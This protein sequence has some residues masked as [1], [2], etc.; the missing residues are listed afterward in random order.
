MLLQPLLATITRQ[1]LLT[2]PTICSCRLIQ[3]KRHLI[4]NLLRALFSYTGTDITVIR[5]LHFDRSGRLLST[6][7]SRKP[8]SPYA[9]LSHRWG[10]AKIVFQDLGANA[11]YTMLIML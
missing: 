10:D 11:P 1:L 7:F 6:D 5:L 8:I 4:P 2:T 9:I 3:F